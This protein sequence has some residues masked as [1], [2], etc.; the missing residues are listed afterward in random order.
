[1]HCRISTYFSTDALLSRRIFL[2]SDSNF[3]LMWLEK[4][5]HGRY[6][7]LLKIT[8]F[9]L[10]LYISFRSS[11]FIRYNCRALSLSSFHFI[12]CLLWLFFSRRVASVLCVRA[13]CI[14]ARGFKLIYRR[15]IFVKQRR[16]VNIC[17]FIVTFYKRHV[18][19]FL[20]SHESGSK[21]PDADFSFSKYITIK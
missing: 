10:L 6:I 1:M 21:D 11:I 16:N 15:A 17:R 5:W 20:T 18:P 9:L 8:I 13:G 7:T 3:V 4:Y 12:L 19:G 2:S 14:F